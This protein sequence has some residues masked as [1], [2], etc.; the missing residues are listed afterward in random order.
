MT[1]TTPSDGREKHVI[2]TRRR[3]KRGEWRA[4]HIYRPEREFWRTLKGIDPRTAAYQRSLVEAQDEYRR[5]VDGGRQRAGKVDDNGM[6][7]TKPPSARYASRFAGLVE[8]IDDRTLVWLARQFLASAQCRALKPVTRQR[9]EDVLRVVCAL[10]Y[11]KRG[12]DCIVGDIFF[13]SF[14]KEGMLAL[15]ARFADTPA[16]ADYVVKVLR[17]C[18]YWGQEAGLMQRVNPA[19]RLGTLSQ[20]DGIAAWGYD[21][22]AAFCQR[23]PTGT[24][25]R[26][27]FDL[28]LYSG[29]RV[30]D[31]H[32]LGPQHLKAGWLHWQEQK[33]K[34]SKA[35]KRRPRQKHRQWKAHPELLAS[36][37]VTTHGIRHF[38]V[39]DDGLPYARP[40]RLGRAFVLWAKEAG[41]AKSAHGIRKLGATLLAD[42]DADLGTIRDFLGHT[43]FQEAET[44]IRNRDLRRASVRAVEL[45]DVARAAK[46][47]A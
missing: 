22:H 47:T 25:Q 13:E 10:P 21:D 1:T 35:L 8:P 27:A 11:P 15:R 2:A 41:I 17:A 46:A 26:L 7:V 16:Q 33:G 30:C 4:I 12:P 31:L 37:A 40:D 38:I 36:I 5:F 24:R 32:M 29:A 28:A 42:N 19:A 34:D 39:R 44:Y 18:F 9:F 14:T 45:M 23:W 43:S 20:S 3:N 6:A